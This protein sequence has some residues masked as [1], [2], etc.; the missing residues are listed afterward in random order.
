MK[1]LP[2]LGILGIAVFCLSLQA[3]VPQKWELRTQEDFL[4]GKFDGVAVSSD[5]A[6][7]LAPREEKIASPT[8]EF[9]LSVLLAPD[10]TT[11]LGTGHGGKVYRIGKDGK[12]EVYFQAAEMDV[13]SL[14]MDKKGTLY[15]ATSPNGKIYKITNK[16]KGET[17][18]DPAEKYI[19]DLEFMDS[20]FLWAA[21]GETGGVY[22]INPQ[23]AGRLI[24]K[25]KE[26]HILCLTRTGRGDVLAGS[27]GNGV[28][29]RISPEGRT[30]VVFE[31]PYEEVRSLAVDPGGII[32][33]AASGMPSKSRKDELPTART[34]T[35][36]APGTAIGATVSTT[37]TAVSVPGVSGTA[38]SASP[39]ASSASQKEPGAVYRISGDGMAKMIWSSGEEMVYSV[40]WKADEQQIIFGTGNNGR[41]YS[42]DKNEKVSLLVQ[43]NSEQVYQLIP[44]DSKVYVLSNNPCYLGQLLTEQRFEGEYV[45]PVLDA[46]ILSSWGRIAWEGIADAGA[47]LQLQTRSGNTYDPNS[48]WSEWSPPYQKKDEQIL[49]PKARFLQ[50]KVLL[51]T[52]AGKVSPVL[53]KL[54]L[55]GLQTNVAPVITRLEYLKPNE[56]LLK[57]PEQEDVILGVEKNL[58]EPPPKKDDLRVVFPAK[59]AE[60]KGFQTIVWDASDE[61]GDTLEYTISLRKEGETEWRVIQAGWT[62]TI[63]AFDTLSYPDGT[64][65]VK[66][67]ASD[68]PSN[69]AGLDLASEKTGPPLVIDNSLPTVK[70]FTAV[71]NGA[72]L[73]VSFQA[74]DAYSYIEEVK[75]LVRPGE[76]RV[77]FPVDG[78]CDST[79]ESFKFSVNLPA[80]AENLITIR[81]KDSYGNVGVYRQTF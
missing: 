24:F 14:A 38:I 66:V 60:H 17:F 36:A 31:T 50:V 44:L 61:N 72:S 29:Y 65:F 23:G 57:L 37:V 18:F 7:S 45:S 74:E 10:G 69:P 73:S 54:I 26:N 12:S 46:K 1:K 55:F 47:S 63:Y 30:S 76:W 67:T 21:V 25:T 51:K 56:V 59:K 41:I 8:E 75:Y 70:N 11:F 40:L 9:Y 3:V 22:E 53:S 58:P 27:G 71:R 5:G 79:S 2:L 52:L 77:V 16:L 13:T 33:A 64:Y 20:G 62:D 4:K 32:Y 80:G 81:V 78:I 39:A 6:L 43:E 42:I 48:T 34:R 49:S 19:W 35:D 28:V 68:A 15:A